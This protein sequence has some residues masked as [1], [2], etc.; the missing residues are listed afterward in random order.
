MS[1]RGVLLVSSEELAEASGVSSAKLRKDLS[2]LGSY[3]TRGVGYEVE[4]LLYQIARALG[5]TQEWPVVIVGI[6]NLGH[7]LAG[8][9]GFA[10]RG[11]SVVGLFDT[12]VNRVGETVVVAGKS[13]VVQD[14]TKL[15]QVVM[16]TGA[17]IGVIATPE[18]AAQDVC[19]LMVRNGISSILNF[20]PTL[21]EVPHGVDMRRVDLATELQILAFHEQRKSQIAMTEANAG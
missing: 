3:G 17:S 12:D 14:L 6:G 15:P 21:L 1:A 9:P 5:L 13:I 19:D 4:F 20:A 10:S 18:T 7:A 11:F 16:S 8:Y 2:F